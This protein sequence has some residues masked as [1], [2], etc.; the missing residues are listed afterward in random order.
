MLE[1]SIGY[2]GGARAFVVEV[3]MVNYLNESIVF[4]VR[5]T[6]MTMR[7]LMYILI[8]LSYYTYV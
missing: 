6:I 4:G 7:I 1:L 2:E 5:W 8:L 3:A